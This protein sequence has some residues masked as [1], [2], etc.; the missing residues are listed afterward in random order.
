MVPDEKAGEK[1]VLHLKNKSL[2][3]GT[4]T[5]LA[6]EKGSLTILPDDAPDA[7]KNV[8]L[9][10]LK[11]IFYVKS[12]GGNKGYKEKKRF[13]LMTSKGR[14]VIVKFYDG[15]IITGFVKQDIP[16]QKGFFLSTLGPDEKGFYLYPSDP[17][18]NNIKI[19][20]V[21][22]SVVEVQRF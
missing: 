11:S 8:N 19:F 7:E 18:S 3:K 12:F 14:K 15:E 5:R 6:S 21:A 17:E 2:L 4:L 20:I 9:D 10:D 16:W 22:T 13:G 1:V